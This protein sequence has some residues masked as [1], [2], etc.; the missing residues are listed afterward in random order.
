MGAT[1]II[2]QVFCLTAVIVDGCSIPF[3]DCCIISRSCCG[4]KYNKFKF[5][6]IYTN[7]SGVYNITNFCGNCNHMTEGYCDVSTAG[8]GWLV[9]QR[10]QDGS[11]DFNRGWVNYEDGFGSLTGEF[12]YGLTPLHCLTNQG[13]WEMRIDFILTDGTKSYLSYS[14]FSVGPASSNY[15]LSISGYNGNASID[16][17]TGSH[18]LNGIPFSTKDK[19]ND[20]SSSKCAVNNGGGN[21]GGWWYRSCSHIYPNNKYKSSY[22]IVLKGWKGLRF[23]EIK[24]RP[25]NCV[26]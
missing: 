4:T 5:S 15:Q 14:S 19:D 22:G 17:I 18:S 6:T 21:A 8:G 3:D 7:T 9:V 12:W 23:T 24:I 26:I 25:I 20:K 10:R 2:L 1:I 13:Q 16:P 11:V